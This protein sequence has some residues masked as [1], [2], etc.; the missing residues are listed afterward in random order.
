MK[1]FVELKTKGV[2]RRLHPKTSAYWYLKDY[3]L[4]FLAVTFGIFL[5][6][7]KK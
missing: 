7:G 1:L 5:L 3:H 6:F 4:L 2:M